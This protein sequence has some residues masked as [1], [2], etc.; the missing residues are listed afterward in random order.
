MRRHLRAISTG[1]RSGVGGDPYWSQGF[2]GSRLRAVGIDLSL[3]RHSPREFVA[4]VTRLKFFR[5]C[6]ASA[7]AVV[8]SQV[9]I[10][11]FNAGLGWSGVRANLA[12]VV[13]ASIPN[14]TINRYWTWQQN[15]RNRL[16]TEVV[17]F[18]TMAVLGTILSTLAVNYADHRWGTPFAVAAA[19]LSGFGVLWVARFIILDRL[20]WRVVHDL[21]PEIDGD[22]AAAMAGGADVH[23]AAGAQL[24]GSRNGNGSG[25]A[26]GANA[27][28]Q[29]NGGHG[30]GQHYTP[31]TQ[32]AA[33]Q[34]P[35]PQQPR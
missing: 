4:E 9:A 26:I 21:H 18:W 3:V 32:P 34:Q 24:A 1:G 33:R 30:N 17:P 6:T 16:W 20:I 35:L 22:D 10:V 13:I 15:G 11:G 14:Y 2:P 12:S 19:Q 7:V 27:E 25:R 31:S 23:E 29:S 8:V 5:Y 28:L